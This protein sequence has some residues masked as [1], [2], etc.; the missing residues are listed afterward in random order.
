M[1]LADFSE[2]FHIATDG[3]PGDTVADFIAGL[4]EAAP[5]RG[6]AIEWA[7]IRFVV[8]GMQGDRITAVVLD[9]EHQRAEDDPTQDV[10]PAETEEVE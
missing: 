8:K 4:L 3:K 2:R 7:G 1:N 9:V 5:T 10:A 6:K